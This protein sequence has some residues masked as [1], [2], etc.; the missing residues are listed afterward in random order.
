MNIK[1]RPVRQG[2]RRARYPGRWLAPLLVLLA[3]VALAPP[4]SADRAFSVRFTTNAQG[5]ITGTGN[6]LLTCRTDDSGCPAARDGDAQHGSPLDNND[7]FMTW[8]DVDGDRST[9]NSSS[10]RLNLP[11]GASILFAGLYYGGRY[12]KG[13][14]GQ[15]PPNPDARNKV[16]LSTPGSTTYQSL[17]AESL[18]YANDTSGVPREYQGFVDITSIVKAGGAG[19]YTVANVQLGTGQNADQSGGWAI[20]VA[21][22][23]PTKP[24]RNL[25]IFDGFKFVT[26]GGASVSIPLSG[27][28]TPN[29]GPVNTRIGMIAYE[30]DL[31]KDGDYATLEGK[32]LSN[33]ANPENNFFNSSISNLGTSFTTRNPNYKNGF[34]FDGDIVDATGY[35]KNGQTKAT[36]T[37]STTSDGYAP[38]GV[39]FATDLFAPSLEPTKVVDKNTAQAGDTLTY[40]MS[41]KN[42]GLDAAVNT[43]IFDPIPAGTTFVPGSLKI[44][45][46]ANAGV[47]TDASGD[48]QADF[49]P[50]G[51]A[52]RF[53]LGTGGTATQGG[54]LA[55]GESTTFSFKVTVNS[56]LA[57]GTALTNIGQISY[58]ADQL[59]IKSEVDTPPATTKVIVP[60]LKIDK[61]HTGLLRA[62]SDDVTFSLVVSNVGTAPSRGTVTVTDELNQYF[63]FAGTPSGTDWA[64]STSGRKLTC[65]RSDSL[66]VGNSWPPIS[67]PV[68][69]A[70]DAPAGQLSNT[71]VVSGGGDGNKNNNTDTDSVEAK[72]DLS[73]DKSADKPTI[74]AG[75]KAAFTIKVTNLGRAQATDVELVDILPEGLKLLKLRTNQGTCTGLT[76]HLGTL[77]RGRVVTLRLI[78]LADSD[79]GGTTLVN[80]VGVDAAETDPYLPNNSDS[81]SVEILKLADIQVTKSTAAASVPVGSDVV[82]T[83]TVYNAGPSDATDVVLN[84]TLPAGLTLKSAEPSQGTC[85]GALSCSLGAL[86]SGGSA[87]ILVTAASAP[88]LSGQTVTNTATAH[89]IEPDPNETNNTDD[90]DV[91]F[92]PEPPQPAN[93]VVTKTSSPSTVVVGEVLTSTIVAT[94]NGPG[95]ASN[96]VVTDT[97]SGPVE[98]VSV[99]T[100]QGSCTTALPIVCDLGPL[101]AGAKATVTVRVRPTAPGPADNGAIAMTPSSGDIQ[102]AP[103]TAQ[104]PTASVRLV[105]SARPR[106]VRGRET[107]TFTIR[108]RS[109]GTDTARNLLLCDRLPAELTFD[110]LGGATLRGGRACWPRFSLAAGHSR[111]FT[112]VAR[113]ATVSHTTRVTNVAAVAGSN[114]SARA[115]RAT[116]V[117]LPGAGRGGGVTG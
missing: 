30:G 92:V 57:D 63:S 115:A 68:N 5:D 90:A 10:A 94:N 34:G 56:A 97:P 2:R 20:A 41:V 43:W 44:V 58:T 12:Q 93:V 76:C 75:Q 113:A 19:T 37:L 31:G 82:Y 25:T 36:I 65:T 110:R 17:T 103:A 50:D 24:T 6:S 116:V 91:T 64:C 69:I 51:N 79:T 11:T 99:T 4:A 73:V 8:V 47:K 71:G 112:L 80:R 16:L 21:Y 84:D 100:T 105:K 49:L 66:A 72:I 13:D 46:G 78:A 98:V 39:S 15:D 32:K 83:I 54:R 14:G 48:D 86:R 3:V 74:Y 28:Q 96:V 61:S 62:G 53:A 88:S 104:S 29:S 45:S 106:V 102:V 77:E 85:Q 22:K 52:V 18:D 26:A 95:P 33:A 87:A 114:V 89:A 7:R 59:G 1:C 35:L 55:I 40:T 27:F 67:V 108:V 42:T 111:S 60:D 101:A 117:I 70:A 23:D 38:G 109:V 107:V 9:F 81:A